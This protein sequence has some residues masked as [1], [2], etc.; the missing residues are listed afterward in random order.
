MAHY[1]WLLIP[2]VSCFVIMSSCS[3]RVVL[4]S[5]TPI[6][7]RVDFEFTGK[8]TVEKETIDFFTKMV[9]MRLPAL[10]ANSDSIKRVQKNSLEL[11]LSTSHNMTRNEDPSAL[12]RSP[13]GF[14]IMRS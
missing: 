1:R 4:E 9:E 6:V 3:Q 11:Y 5:Q 2:I 13:K 10:D 8:K 14:F 12:R 7:I